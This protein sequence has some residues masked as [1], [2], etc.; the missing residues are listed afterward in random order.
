M[1][2]TLSAL[3]TVAV[4]SADWRNE[5]IP[6][7]RTATDVYPS[8]RDPNEILTVSAMPGMGMPGT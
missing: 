1:Y 6:V 5:V 4:G 8:T 2:Q 7:S 3:T